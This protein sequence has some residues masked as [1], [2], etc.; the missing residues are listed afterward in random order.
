M[1]VLITGGAGYIGSHIALEFLDMG[2]PVVILDNLSTGRD[3]LVPDKAV[4][5]KGDTRDTPTLERAMR[6]HG[7]ETVV[8]CAASTSVPESAAHPLEYY[9]NNVQGTIS[10]LRAMSAS[11]VERIIFSSTAAVYAVGD[12]APRIEQSPVDPVSPYGRTKLIAERLIQ[13]VAAIG[14]LRY[15]ILRYFNVAG[16]DPQRRS[17]QSTPNATHL[18]KR[19]LEAALGKRPSMTIFGTDWPTPDGTGIRDFVHVS[20]LARAHAM[21]DSYLASGGASD[22][23][24]CGYGH[25]YSVLEVIA[26]VEEISGVPLNVVKAARRPGD[27]P[28]VIADPGHIRS[29]IGWKP[30]HDDLRTI[31]GHAFEWERA[32]TR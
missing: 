23:M 11:S 32:Q 31:I 22:V 18:I 15:A 13:D 16:A 1:S 2:R 19:A 7:V 29:A 21:A 12:G 30:S 26:M 10:L 28:M 20:D 9:E 25:G 3:F 4:F 8:H 17:G 5:V 6:E 24:N 14:P 27:L